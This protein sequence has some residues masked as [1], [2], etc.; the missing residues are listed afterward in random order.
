MKKYAYEN[1]AIFESKTANR[2]SERAEE[3]RQGIL[4]EQKGEPAIKRY[5]FVIVAAIIMFL[6]IFFLVFLR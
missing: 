4:K 5:F 6:A 1:P 2:P 3:L